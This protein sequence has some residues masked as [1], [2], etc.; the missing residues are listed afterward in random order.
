MSPQTIPDIETVRAQTAQVATVKNPTGPQ[1][2]INPQNLSA[3]LVEPQFSLVRTSAAEKILEAVGTAIEQRS[4]EGA[5]SAR[6]AFAPD[7]IYPEPMLAVLVS[8]AWIS[9]AEN[10]KTAGYEVS[11]LFGPH[12]RVYYFTVSWT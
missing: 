7:E 10:L 11:D 1:Q 6:I 3:Q 5:N 4:G 12:D 9:A 8:A 2:V